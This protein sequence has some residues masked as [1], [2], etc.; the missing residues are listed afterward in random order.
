MYY[1]MFSAVSISL[2]DI[3]CI[4]ISILNKLI[5]SHWATKPGAIR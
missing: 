5:E 3:T 2:E 1:N 4:I